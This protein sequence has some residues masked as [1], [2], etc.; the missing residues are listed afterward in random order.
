MNNAVLSCQNIRKHFMQGGKY[1]EVLRD[2][3]A[4]FQQ[5]GTYAIT[6]VS[7][8]GKSTF[9]HVLAGLD[10]LSEGS[11]FFNEK[12]I[13]SFSSVERQQFLNNHI[14]LVFQ[15]PYLVRELTVLENIMLPGLIGGKKRTSCIKKANELLKK[16]DLADKAQSKPASLSGGQQQRVALLR[17]VFNEPNF[18]LADEPTGNLDIQT[19]KIIVELLLACQKEWNMGIIVSTH[20]E[21]VAHAMGKVYHISGGKLVDG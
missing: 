11:I 19:G 7:G 15:L 1:I 12:N 14:G 17:A 2:I 21:Y 16:V 13:A 8:T 5:G 6:G 4:V 18:L 20:D 9:M 10:E 3:S